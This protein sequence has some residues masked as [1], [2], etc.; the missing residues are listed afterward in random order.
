MSVTPDAGGFATITLDTVPAAGSVSVGWITV[1]NLSASSG[2]SSGGTAAAKEASSTVS[3]MPL[4]GGANPPATTTRVPLSNGDIYAKYMAGGGTRALN[5]ETVYIEV[6]ASYGADG[7]S[8]A[9][10]DVAGVTWS[11]SEITAGAKDINGTRYKRWG[12]GSAA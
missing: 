3:Y 1:R 11:E 2:A 12:N 6:G 5:G 4:P 7:Y 10:P 8:Y 9:V